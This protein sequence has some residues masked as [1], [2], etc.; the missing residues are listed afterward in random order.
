MSS[1]KDHLLNIGLEEVL[2]GQQPPDL[3]ARILAAAAQRQPEGVSSEKAVVSSNHR[4]NLLPLSA[5]VDEQVILN[6]SSHSLTKSQTVSS[7]QLTFN[8]KTTFSIAASILFVVGVSWWSVQFQRNSSELVTNSESLPLLEGDRVFDPRL[9]SDVSSES[10]SED[11]MENHRSSD[12]MLSPSPSELVH[13]ETSGNRS[14]P[15][16]DDFSDDETATSPPFIAKNSQ[17]R[18][19][20]SPLAS[21]AEEPSLVTSKKSRSQQKPSGTEGI[22]ASASF[23]EDVL[24]QRVNFEIE[25]R[26]KDVDVYPAPPAE[27]AE[28]CRRVFVDVLGRIPTA[29]EISY[30]TADP[31]PDKRLHLI[32]RLLY[33]EPYAEEFA[34][35]W[36]TIW[37]NQLIGRAGGRRANAQVNREALHEWLAT[38]FHNNLPYNE[39]VSKLISV[40]G[41]N[42]PTAP[43]YQGATN[44]LLAHL[45]QDQVPATNKVSELFL[46]MQ[47]GCTQ[48][49]HHP[50]NDWKQ[51]H[52][53][54]LNA[55]F[56]QTQAVDAVDDQGRKYTKL[57]NRDFSG[58]GANTIDA[59]EIYYEQRNGL[60]KVAYPTFLDGTRIDPN[61]AVD[62]IVRR[63]ALAKLLTDHHRFSQAFVNRMWSHFL[64]VGFTQRIEDWGPHQPPSHPQVLQELANAFTEQG[65]DQKKLIRWIVSTEAYGLSSRV[66]PGNEADHPESGIYPLFSRFYIRQMEPEVLYDSLL[67]ATLPSSVSSEVL[68]QTRIEHQQTRLDWVQQFVVT[69]N[70]EENTEDSTFDGSVSQALMMMNGP[71][72]EEATAMTPGSFLH[73]LAYQPGKPTDKYNHL[74]LAALGR[75][76]ARSEMN[77]AQRFQRSH[78]GDLLSGMQDVWWVLLNSNEFIMNH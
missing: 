31:S 24:L 17:Q 59:A 18:D 2:G 48:C 26:W 78:G 37:C 20:S 11:K 13:S 64:G 43:N 9:Q 70:T 61:G 38:A 35:Y 27:D 58:Q 62:Q 45:E 33:A 21:P 72:M 12:P 3:T 53:W 30:F 16:V 73:Q 55:F 23:N 42:Q 50:F 10:S 32:D 28:W 36:A 46:G 6:G 1:P 14:T 63:D 56:K 22:Y 19:A 71:F 44:F 76:P 52:F 60:L 47:I 65:Y 29:E 7:R 57:V 51:E 67:T 69:F 75:P 49:H 15:T 74:F 34:Q 40:T 25:Q 5:D 39:L 68:L 41:S 8:W 4:A 77:F 66:T 54:G